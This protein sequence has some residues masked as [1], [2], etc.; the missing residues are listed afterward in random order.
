MSKLITWIKEHKAAA[1]ALGLLAVMLIIAACEF[2]FV[3]GNNQYTGWQ[4]L[5]MQG[6]NFWITAVVC[7]VLAGLVA[8]YVVKKIKADDGDSRT[9]FVPGFIVIAAFLGIAFGK[10]CTDK[11]NDGVGTEKGRPTQVIDST[12]VPAEDLIPKK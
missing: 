3:K 11:A 8:G 6:A 1:I 5:G 9:T 7:S 12:R 10:G 4:I 2:L